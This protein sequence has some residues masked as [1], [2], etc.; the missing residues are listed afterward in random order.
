MGSSV[1]RSHLPRLAPEFY[2]GLAVVHWT[3]TIHER[4][5]GWLTPEFHARCREVLL[6]TMVRYQLLSPACCLMPDHA[7]FIW[8]GIDEGADSALAVEFFRRHTNA[9]LGPRHW[10]REP[11]DHV[12][13]EN[14]RTRGAFRSICH[15]VFANPVRKEMVQS[16]QEYPF[17]GATLPGYPDVDPR[18]E[19]FWEVFWKIYNAKLQ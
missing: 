11:Y 10:Q 5:L 18:R 13:R 8:M 6:H 14:A 1:H 19:G 4:Q 3:M 7:H 16:W 9:F 12:L 2:R 15:Y 17:S